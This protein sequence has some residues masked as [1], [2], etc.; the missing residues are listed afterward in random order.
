[1]MRQAILGAVGLAVL[2]AGIPAGAVPASTQDQVVLAMLRTPGFDRQPPAELPAA[3]R[4]IDV[5]PEVLPEI[6]LHL[7]DSVFPRRDNLILNK[8]RD[9]RVRSDGSH[10]TGR[11]TIREETPAPQF[12]LLPRTGRSYGFSFTI[13]F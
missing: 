10:R 3:S 12:D 2:A 8:L 6:K 9:G 1:M 13:R 5:L 4:Y 7:E 11:K